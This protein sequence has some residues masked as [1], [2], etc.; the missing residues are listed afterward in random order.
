VPRDD[1]R[2]TTLCFHIDANRINAAAKLESMNQLERWRAAGVI[3][4]EMAEPAQ[5][6]A[7]RGSSARAEKAMNYIYAQAM[8]GTAGEKEL[9]RKIEGILFPNGAKTANELRDVEIV[10][11]AGKYDC[12]LVTNDGAS[13]SQPGGILGNREKL[14]KLRIKVC[15]DEEAVAVVRERIARRDEYLRAKSRRIGTPLPAW[16]GC[17]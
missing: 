15:T 16:V 13:R 11:I 10:F 7:M 1:R 9:L 5:N 4:I 17:D 14:A 6:E 12:I 3:D 8:A 2:F